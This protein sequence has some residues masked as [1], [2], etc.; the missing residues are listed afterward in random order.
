MQ[1]YASSSLITKVPCRPSRLKSTRQLLSWFQKITCIHWIGLGLGLG[2]GLG[3][4]VSRPPLHETWD[5]RV[6]QEGKGRR[7]EKATRNQEPNPEQEHNTQEIRGKSV[8]ASEVTGHTGHTGY[9]LPVSRH[10]ETHS[11]MKTFPILRWAIRICIV[12]IRFCSVFALF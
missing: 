3:S 12:E 7:S 11:F 2:L 9:E 1:I 8:F 6:Q 4:K 10:V 5:N